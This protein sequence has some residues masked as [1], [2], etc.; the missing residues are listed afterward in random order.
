MQKEY[1]V[2]FRQGDITSLLESMQHFGT[3]FLRDL[4]QC[5]SVRYRHI[6]KKGLIVAV[7]WPHKLSSP[8]IPTSPLQVIATKIYH[9]RAP[10]KSAYEVKNKFSLFERPFKMEKGGVFLFLISS[11]VP[12][13]FTI[14][15]YAN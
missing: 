3:K 6:H 2:S 4:Y 1:W 9:C 15:Y 7:T 5:A 14:L 8:H 13:I 10:I 12:E 11:L